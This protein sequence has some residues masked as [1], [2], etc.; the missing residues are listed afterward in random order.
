MDW[1]KLATNY[2]DDPAI[3]RAGEAAE[4][5]FTRA[6]AYVGD[7]ETDG[8]VPRE[9]LPRLTP[10]NGVT[11]ARA[12]VS[13]GLWE[14][15]PE[16]WRFLAWAKH[17]TTKDQLDQRRAGGAARQAAYRERHKP[18]RNAVTD[19]VSHSGVTPREV[20]VEVEAAAAAAAT[21]PK[22]LPPALA[23]LRAQLEAHKLVVQWSSLTEGDH[24]EIEDLIRIHGDNA[25]V[26]SALR[27]YQPNRPPATARA[28]LKQWRDLRA[29]G[30]LR[31]VADPCPGHGHTGTTKHCI[32]CASEQKEATR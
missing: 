12:L 4:I 30:D 28:W 23:I 9:V 25:L 8:V 16:G 1:V 22:D 13:E 7:Q 24:A 21:H 18:A 15:I 26:K 19:A 3:M 11:R 31:V 10:R 29:P 14:V 17:Q 27:S 5:L 20:E 32:Q 2:Y 6:L